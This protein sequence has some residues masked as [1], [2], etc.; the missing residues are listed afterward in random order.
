M[1]LRSH[2]AVFE[3]L[4]ARA[5]IRLNRPE[6][7]NRLGNAD[8]ARIIEMLEAVEQETHVRVLIVSSGGPTFCSG[9]DLD[10]LADQ[11][12]RNANDTPAFD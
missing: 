9:Y 6:R 5:M 4:G 3:V 11:K 12:V 1:D 10:E 7:H 8:I 2:P